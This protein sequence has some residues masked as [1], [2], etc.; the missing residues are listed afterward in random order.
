M[1]KTIL[2]QGQVNDVGG[3]QDD[4]SETYIDATEQAQKL[5]ELMKEKKLVS[6]FDSFLSGLHGTVKY[7]GTFST[8]YDVLNRSGRIL[9][10]ISEFVN[11]ADSNELE[12]QG[13]IFHSDSKNVERR[14][15]TG[16]YTLRSEYN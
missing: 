4:L 16:V 15:A 12:I 10:D 5:Y 7:N 1:V 3:W 9:I 11:G 6:T 8:G 13:F 14:V 2:K